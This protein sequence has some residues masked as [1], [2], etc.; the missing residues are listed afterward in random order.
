M[1]TFSKN[2]QNFICLNCKKEVSKLG[3]SSRNHCP[4]CLHSLHV[5]V[6]PGDRASDCKGVLEPVFIET[7]SQKGY[8]INFKCKKCGK[9][10]RN[11]A[12][13]DDSIKAILDVS[14]KA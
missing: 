7:N 9:V 13:A 2:D 3:Y 1:K 12:A 10:V 11:K 14:R 5:D 4:Y 6:N 8:I